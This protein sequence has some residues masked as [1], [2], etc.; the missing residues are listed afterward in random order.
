ME[1]QR[2]VV[3]NH[4]KLLYEPIKKDGFI[5]DKMCDILTESINILNHQDS[6]EYDDHLKSPLAVLKYIDDMREAYLELPEIE[7]A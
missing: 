5:L 4:S 7:N 2:I 3:G 6:L 1:K